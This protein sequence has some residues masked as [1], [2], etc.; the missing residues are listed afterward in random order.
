G[1]G[2][3][4][5]FGL[6]VPCGKTSWQGGDAV[7][8]VKETGT[9]FVYLVGR[10]QATTH[11]ASALLA[12]G[13][14]AETVQVSRNSL[15]GLPRGPRT[16]IPHHADALPDAARLLDGGWTMCSEPAV[17][18]TGAPTGESVLLVGEHPRGGRDAGDAAVLVEVSGGDRYLLWRGHRHRILPEALP[19]IETVLGA[20]PWLTVS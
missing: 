7:I 13:A 16:G 1:L 14:H 11:C 6:F 5:V 19:V 15:Y 8:V 3:A 4:F 9:R 10:V 2:I 18:A 20:R 12:L 17:D